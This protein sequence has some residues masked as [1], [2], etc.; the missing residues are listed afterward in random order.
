MAAEPGEES[1][2]DPVQSFIDEIFDEM[3]REAGVPYKTGTKREKD[4]MA[5]A[6]VEAALDSLSRPTALGGSEIERVLLAQILAGALAEAL[7]P[8]LADAL[9]VEIM[10]VLKHH[11]APQSDREESAAAGSAARGSGDGARKK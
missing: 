11:V 9:T 4:P 3:T 2:R 1:E 6:L 7:A 5:A 10:K 8:S